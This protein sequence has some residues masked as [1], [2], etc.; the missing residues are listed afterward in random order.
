LSCI[1]RR[2]DTTLHGGS[3]GTPTTSPKNLSPS[4]SSPRPR[5]ASSKSD[6][7]PSTEDAW[8]EVEIGRLFTG[9]V[10]GEGALLTNAPRR[11]TAKAVT[12]VT[13]LSLDRVYF[14]DCLKSL[15]KT[16]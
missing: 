7:D 10:F 15:C 1:T 12:D 5:A 6:P 9:Q 3:D 14:L 13:V 2:K 4:Q 8:S 16:Y 11:A